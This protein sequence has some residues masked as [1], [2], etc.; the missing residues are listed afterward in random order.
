MPKIP[1][2]N[3]PDPGSGREDPAPSPRKDDVAAP[4]ALP[5][6]TPGRR[7]HVKDYLAEVF[8]S[9]QQANAQGKEVLESMARALW[10]NGWA[11]AM[12]EKGKSRIYRVYSEANID[13][14]A[15]PTPPF[16]LRRGQELAAQICLGNE[17]VCGLSDFADEMH[18]IESRSESARNANTPASAQD[19]VAQDLRFRAEFSE[20]MSAAIARLSRNPERLCQGLQRLL[21]EGARCMGSDDLDAHAN[22]FGHSLAVQAMG[23]GSFWADGI[24]DGDLLNAWKTNVKIPNLDAASLDFV[25]AEDLTWKGEYYPRPGRLMPSR[26]TY[27][28]LVPQVDGSLQIQGTEYFRENAER[29][30]DKATVQ[31]LAEILEDQM[32]NGWD[33][34]D[35]AEIGAL[36]EAPIISNGTMRNS[37]GELRPYPGSVCYAH[38][39][40]Q[41]E[42]P[43]ETLAEGK[44]VVLV[45]AELNP[46]STRTYS[47]DELPDGKGLREQVGDCQVALH[48]GEVVIWQTVDDGAGKGTQ[49]WTVGDLDEVLQDQ[50]FKDV[51]RSV[52]EWLYDQGEP[53]DVAD[54]AEVNRRYLD[55]ANDACVEV[56]RVMGRDFMHTNEHDRARVRNIV[57]EFASRTP[58]SLN[59][60]T[61]EAA[62]WVER[63]GFQGKD[64]SGKASWIREFL[65]AAREVAVSSPETMERVKTSW[66]LV[67]MAQEEHDR[68][69][70]QSGKP[71]GGGRP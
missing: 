47:L 17:A 8:D 22:R 30:K 43:I 46:F 37:D 51:A 36:T 2:S 1:F 60:P 12:E 14:V 5:V 26:G 11:R 63:V 25:Q 55:Q 67:K 71:S 41:I 32:G 53:L 69:A 62:E 48:G 31:A 6:E 16:M 40:Y 35:P 70:F 18:R 15:P 44:A 3:H 56:A 45:R 57:T 68:K 27:V 49:M 42:D 65:Q 39:D 28:D 20:A 52:E 13:E 33:W 38:M 66:G 64:W 9:P 7:A 23:Q 50:E 24:K 54:L 61:A 4:A 34:V 58:K 19:L 10:L 29:F 21:A 59:Q